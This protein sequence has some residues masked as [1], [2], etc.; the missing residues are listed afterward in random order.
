MIRR[1]LFGLDLSN[2]LVGSTLGWIDLI[3]AHS[4]YVN[5]EVPFMIS[6]FFHRLHVEGNATGD[7]PVSDGDT[8]E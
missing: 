2:P 4:D 1:G 6:R 3:G 7:A 5:E 8:G